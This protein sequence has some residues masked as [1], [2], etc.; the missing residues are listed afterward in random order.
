[1]DLKPTFITCYCPVVS[2]TPGSAYAQH[3]IYMAENKESV[4]DNIVCPRQLFGYDLR[5]I[6]GKYSNIG[7]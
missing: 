6:T 2:G 4:P 1:M 5:R 7:N 3:L